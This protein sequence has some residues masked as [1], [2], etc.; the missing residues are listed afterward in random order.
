MSFR[1]PALIEIREAI[2]NL[3]VTVDFLLDA[4]IPLKKDYLLIGDENNEAKEVSRISLTNL[5]RLS[6]P[7]PGLI[8][9]TDLLGNFFFSASLIELKAKDNTFSATLALQNSQIL[10]N[11]TA[12]GAQGLV[13]A[14]ISTD[15]AI[16]NTLTTSHSFAIFGLEAQFLYHGFRIDS[17]ASDVDS[18]RS[19]ILET[20]DSLE[21]LEKITKDIGSDIESIDS[22]ISDI[23]YEAD[24]L[25]NF[26]TKINSNID[27]IILTTEQLEFNFN[28]LKVEI[29]LD[30]KDIEE[31]IEVI[32]NNIEDIEVQ[33]DEIND[34][35][36]KI[37]SNI[38]TIE[39]T[40]GTLNGSIETLKQN[41]S[42]LESDI[43][44][45]Q[46][47]INGLDS[48]ITYQGNQIISNT[49]S[50]STQ[51]LVIYGISS[52][53]SVINTLTTSHT[54]ALS[55]FENSLESIEAT[56]KDIGDS[57]DVIESNL[58]D[59][60]YK[61]YGIE[62]SIEGV[63][64][65]IKG[66]QSNIDEIDIN[67]NEINSDIINS[68]LGIENLGATKADKTADFL[69]VSPNPSYPNSKTL[70]GAN[71][72]TTGGL[73]LRDG[74]KL[75]V[76]SGTEGRPIVMGPGGQVSAGSN[77]VFEPLMVE[78]PFELGLVYF[79]GNL[80]CLMVC[81]NED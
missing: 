46:L 21:S 44:A 73:L 57:I 70:T 32:S 60:N 12:I 38:I 14:G 77:L 26:I 66:L 36:E 59:L 30:F 4:P 51:E 50:I 22:K 49:N 27:S 71:T 75:S 2:S 5:P 54:M 47:D 29:E 63:N 56:T 17:I 69:L 11:T 79:D 37:Q 35:I 1:S 48:E 6:P 78:P 74:S 52:D 9:E 24:V 65:N 58:V 72:A 68:N 81:V 62:D 80:N 31:S 19:S 39:A 53:L 40:Y 20:E 16:L 61:F 7:T 28:D 76:L 33:I 41:F 42:V 43:D 34:S 64:F 67:I 13:L 25:E 3:Q 45:L 10:A 8:L 15:L 23:T 18:L 55:E